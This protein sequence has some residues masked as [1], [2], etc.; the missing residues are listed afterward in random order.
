MMGWV[1]LFLTWG[2]AIIMGM[3]MTDGYIPPLKEPLKEKFVITTYE[4]GYCMNTETLASRLI[5]T[6]ES[7]KID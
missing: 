5:R 2:V 7:V 1:L 4:N 6:V 3:Q